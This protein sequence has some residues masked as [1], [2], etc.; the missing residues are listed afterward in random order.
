MKFLILIYSN[1]KSR[2]IWETLT[3]AQQIEFG[4]S[5]MALSESLAASGDL[6]VAEGLADQEL[7]RRVSVR[8][9]KTITSDGPFA[10]VKEYLAGFYLIECE[11]ME[12]AVEIA[13]R[14]PDASSG[15]VEV[16]PVLDLKAELEM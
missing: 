15:E 10:E 2:A 8:D 7:A 14:I 12:G 1:P 5:H 11:S 4:R 16:R 13:A 6:I 9:G 3:D